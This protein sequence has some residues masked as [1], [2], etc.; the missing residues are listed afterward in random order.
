VFWAKGCWR[1]LTME[2]YPVF[3]MQLRYNVIT[4]H[5]RVMEH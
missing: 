4:S 2:Y 1:P 5:G 3:F